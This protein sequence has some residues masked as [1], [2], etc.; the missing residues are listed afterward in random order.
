MLFLELHGVQSGPAPL[1]AANPQQAR[2]PACGQ[3]FKPSP[4]VV[5]AI[6]AADATGLASECTHCHHPLQFNPFFSATDDYADVL[7]R[8][9][10]LSR[11]EK[12]YD[13]EET[14]AHLA[15]LA[16]HLTLEGKADE[17]AEYQRGYDDRVRRSGS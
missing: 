15:A 10:E 9:L 6:R 16:A 3:E 17:A 8:G 12:G 2:C 7:R 1:T 5:S 13:H 14:L 4:A 11:R